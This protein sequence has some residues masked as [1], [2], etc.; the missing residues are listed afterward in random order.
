MTERS[1]ADVD[2]VYAAFIE[3]VDL[4]GHVHTLHRQPFSAAD[5][6]AVKLFLSRSYIANPP[7]P[8]ALM[9]ADPTAS[10]TVRQSALKLAE[11]ALLINVDGAA[12][13]H[14]PYLAWCLFVGA[15]VLFVEA[16]HS[17]SLPSPA[18]HDLL[19]ALSLCGTFWDLARRYAT[20]LTRA[21]KRLDR[22]NPLQSTSEDGAVAALLDFRKTSAATA[23]GAGGPSGTSTPAIVVPQEGEYGE[24]SYGQNEERFEGLNGLLADWVGED[25]PSLGLFSWFELP[26][27]G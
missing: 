26:T 22:I 2:S 10:A 13:N 5:E 27:A 9:R 8:S 7:Q 20:L 21:L 11:L 17:F 23:V 24:A 1:T 16:Y 12:P 18:F 4:L 6:E 15:R 19:S 3:I 14:S 25:E